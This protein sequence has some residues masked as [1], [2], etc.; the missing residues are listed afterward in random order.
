M[1]TGRRRGALLA[2]TAASA[3][4][5]GGI[6]TAAPAAGAWLVQGTIAVPVSAVTPAPP[7]LQPVV[8]QRT[9]PI[10]QIPAPLLLDIEPPGIELPGIEPPG[11]ELPDIELPDLQPPPREPDPAPAPAEEPAAADPATQVV[12][13]TNAERRDA[14]C[15]SLRTDPQLTAAAQGHSED[16]AERGY[17]DHESRDGRDFVDRARAEGHEQPGGENIAAGQRTAAAVVAA[18]MDSPGHRRNILD[19]DFSTIGVGYEPR[20][21]HWVQ[22]FGY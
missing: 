8:A 6:A 18:W 1:S 19:C 10:P 4:L 7:A 22:N 2:A 15:G 9:S 3:L 21:H 16:M 14:G 12:D 11:I 20:G 13:L 5:A 17:F